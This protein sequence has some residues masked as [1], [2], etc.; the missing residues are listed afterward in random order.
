[1]NNIKLKNEPRNSEGLRSGLKLLASPP[2]SKRGTKFIGRHEEAEQSYDASNQVFIK[3][4][5]LPGSAGDKISPGRQD[6]HR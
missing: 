1:M 3:A 5:T 2:F 6:F 4:P